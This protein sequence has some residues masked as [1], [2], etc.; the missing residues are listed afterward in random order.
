MTLLRQKRIHS[1]IVGYNSRMNAHSSFL[2][3]F[4][5]HFAVA[6]FCSN[7]ISQGPSSNSTTNWP[8][9]RGTAFNGH[10][11]EKDIADQWP[12]EG[13]PVLW[14][15][16]LGQGYSAFIA[17][18]QCI[19]TQYQQLSGQYLIC[20]A[21]D[22]GKTK[23]EYRYDW[24]Y[25]PAGVYP[26]PRST[27]TFDSGFVYFTSP[28][29]LVVCLN[30]DTGVKIWAIELELRFGIKAPGFGY[31]CSPIVAGDS[32][33]L[34]V[35]ARNASVVALDKK[36]G[37]TKWKAVDTKPIAPSSKSTSKESEASYCSAYPIV[38]QGRSFIVC[39]LQNAIVCHDSESGEQ[40]W[41]TSLSSGYDEHSAWPIYDEPFL[42]I[43]GAFQRGSELLEI[44]GNSELPIRLVRQSKL[45][46]NDIFSSVL[47]DGALFGFDLHEAQAKTHRTSRGIF[48]C[49]DFRS[50][51]ELWS[52]GTGRLQR[53][54][55][56][57]SGDAGMISSSQ[58]GEK[59]IGHATVLVA[60][61]KLVLMND[62]GE[63]ILAKASREKY[64]ELA[65][66]TL[67]GGEICW[68]QPAISQKR[69]FVRNHSRAVCVYLGSAESLD[70][71]LKAKAILP[72]QIPQG[73]VQDLA[74]ILIGIE[75]E[76][77]F[78]LPTK[79][80]LWRWYWV[81]LLI[82]GVSF[83]F[84]ET[85]N[86][87]LQFAILRNGSRATTPLQQRS[88]IGSTFLCTLIF[89]AGAIGTTILS[90]WTEEFIFTWQLCLYVA[91]HVAVANLSKR[92]VKL[93]RTQRVQS[94]LAVLFLLATCVIYFLLCRRLS[95]VFEWVFLSGFLAALPFSLA[96]KASFAN[97]SWKSVWRFTM[98][99]LGFSAYYWASVA[100]LFLRSG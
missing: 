10:S 47:H 41:R 1:I 89:L 54:S 74:S 36:T 17:W 20:M 69:L 5:C 71:Q 92:S 68:T 33:V 22:S 87:G 45:M 34:P 23:W 11:P 56:N 27:P 98:T 2:Y 70:P 52:I 96:G 50:G 35:G 51:E 18:D 29:G 15:R 72:S 58:S 4:L 63:L 82:I 75:P 67:L 25:D 13:P 90:R 95:L 73:Q 78:D 8:T 83:V 30:A 77:L 43:S 93:S 76:Y 61:N 86:Q 16:E 53:N 84:A 55:I 49:I 91:W 38:F 26:G 12:A 24:P 39:Y 62:L 44:T 97:R 65:R 79:N 81:S 28:S 21:A 7:A 40:L 88:G 80:W 85:I 37:E 31:A 6:L 99:C 94:W 42:W 19:A 9:I 14:S 66:T 100:I 57:A 46:S 3:L 32:I 60:D 59:N 48:R 64:E